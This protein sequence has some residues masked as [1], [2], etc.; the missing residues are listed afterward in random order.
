VRALDTA[1]GYEHERDERDEKKLLLHSYL[2]T[3]A[4]RA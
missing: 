3:L 1:E 4:C 2:S